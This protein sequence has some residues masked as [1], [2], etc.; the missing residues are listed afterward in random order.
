MLSSTPDLS[1]AASAVQQAGGRA[2][3]E[4]RRAAASV[5]LGEPPIVVNDGQRWKYFSAGVIVAIALVVTGI[6]LRTKGLF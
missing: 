1:G 3:G 5:R 6:V 2:V 4:I